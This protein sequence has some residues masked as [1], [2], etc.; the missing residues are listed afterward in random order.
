MVTGRGIVPPA[1]RDVPVALTTGVSPSGCSV[2]AKMIAGTTVMSCPNIVPNVVLPRTFSART[3][4]VYPSKLIS[5]CKDTAPLY[6][7]A[8]YIMK[9][10]VDIIMNA[11]K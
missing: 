8:V 9:L 4:A 7:F 2:T 1:G 10:I 6:L 11:S 3:T 5:S